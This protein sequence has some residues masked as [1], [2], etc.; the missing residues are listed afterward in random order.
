M[1]WFCVL[2]LMSAAASAA[3]PLSVSGHF[4]RPLRKAKN[5]C[6]THV[7]AMDSAC[8]TGAGSFALPPIISGSVLPSARSSSRPRARVVRRPGLALIFTVSPTLIASFVRPRW[9]ESGRRPQ[10]QHQRTILGV[11][12]EI[13]VRVLPCELGDHALDDDLAAGIKGRRTVM[14]EGRHGDECDQARQYAAAVH[15]PPLRTRIRMRSMHHFNIADHIADS[16][17]P[18]N[19]LPEDG[20]TARP[21]TMRS[22][23]T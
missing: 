13:A 3:L 17:N 9:P 1:H 11:H 16:T 23:E 5:P 10:L 2:F 21:A 12:R 4:E 22:Q 6:G 15:A 18:F 19:C 7:P 8:C 14:R 20:E